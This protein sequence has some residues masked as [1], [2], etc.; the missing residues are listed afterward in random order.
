MRFIK[1]KKKF[2]IYPDDEF[3]NNWDMFV[4][5]VLILTCVV[6]PVRIVF[7]ENEPIGWIIVNNLVDFIFLMDIVFTFNMAYYDELCYIVQDRK[8]ISLRYIRSWFILDVFAIIPF[9][10]LTHAD[11]QY[12]EMV[13]FTRLGKMNKLIK[14][15]RL[16]RLLKIIKNK[17]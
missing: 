8:L 6:T 4:S 12:N 10:Y 14:L 3:K 16:I 1:N 17:N 5:A 2:M 15:T 11:K 9:H 7:V 13:R